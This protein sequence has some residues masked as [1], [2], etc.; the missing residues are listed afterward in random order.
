MFL[1]PLTVCPALP[2]PESLEAAGTGL[3]VNSRTGKTDVNPLTRPSSRSVMCLNYFV[4]AVE[5]PAATTNSLPSRTIG[6]RA[7]LGRHLQV[8]GSL[9]WPLG[10]RDDR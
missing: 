6:Q 3:M 7:H 5:G 2:L 8:V 9:A 1:Q 10:V 4:A